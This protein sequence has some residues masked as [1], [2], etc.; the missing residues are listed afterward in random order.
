MIEP[1][2]VIL[3]LANL[4]KHPNMYINPVNPEILFSFFSGL[5]RGI[6]LAESELTFHELVEARRLTMRSMGFVLTAA[7]PFR[8]LREK[9]FADDEIISRMIDIE[10]ESW[11]LLAQWIAERQASIQ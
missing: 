9:G 5:Q 3:E 7:A 2:A 10:M 4:K 6:L 11:R 1:E 8:E